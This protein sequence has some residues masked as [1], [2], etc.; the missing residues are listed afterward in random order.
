MLA[1]R[2]E[3]W[4]L[5]AHQVKH[6]LDD[7]HERRLA[8]AHEPR[9]A[10]R[11][12]QDPAEHI[13]APLIAREYSVGEQE[14]HG[15]CVVREH[16][17]ARRVAVGVDVRLADDQRHHV[18]QRPEQIGVVVV[19]HALHHRRD[20]LES[21]TGVDRGLGERLEHAVR[22]PVE[23]HEHE[24]PDLKEAPRFGALHERLLRELRAHAI[25]PLAGRS[26]RE[27]E[28][29]RNVRQVDVDL[30]AGAAGAGIGHLPEVV[31]LA[32]PVDATRGDPSD[33]A[34]ERARLVVVLVNGDADMLDRDLQLLGDE[35]PGKADRVALEVVAEREVAEHLEKG[36]V[37]C[38]VPHLFE[39]V[40][41][42]AGA[43]A[44]L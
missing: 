27:L 18:Q 9:M 31:L 22:L 7:M 14:A 36:V 32:E 20:P 37:P 26:R 28:V 35:L 11:A 8:A 19:R 17:V 13:A 23:L 44:L 30:R 1:P 2:R 16:T 25:G 42:A 5:L 12:T 3:F 43:D 24:V 34:P 33:F 38:S 29:L 40:V 21:R 10:H 4:E 15:A 6:L 41:L 39:V